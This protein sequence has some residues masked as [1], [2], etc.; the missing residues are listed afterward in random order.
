MPDTARSAVYY[1]FRDHVVAGVNWRRTR[2]VDDIPSTRVCCVCRTIPKRTV[3]L[4]CL[5]ALCVHCHAA[6]RQ[7]GGVLCTLDQEPFEEEECVAVDFPARKAESVKVYCWN[8]DQGCDYVGTMGG[9][10]RHYENECAFHKVECSACN[11]GVLHKDIPAHYAAGC[12]AATA[13]AARGQSSSSSTELTSQILSAAVEDLKAFLRDSQ[14][15]QLLPVVQSQLNEL[16]EH[17][18]NQEVSLARIAREIRAFEKYY[19]A[20][21]VAAAIPSSTSDRR[22]CRQKPWLDFGALYRATTQSGPR[23]PAV[24]A[25]CQLVVSSDD[26][27][28]SLTSVPSTSRRWCKELLRVTYLLTLDNAEEVF[29]CRGEAERKL[30]EVTVSHMS[31]TNLLLAVSKRRNSFEVEIQFD[32]LLPG[33]QCFPPPRRVTALHPD[34]RSKNLNLN[35]RS[36]ENCSCERRRGQLEHLHRTFHTDLDFLQKAGFLR[37]GKMAFKIELVD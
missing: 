29:A 6:N 8:E 19:Q 11:E 5:H 31:D 37:D 30:A 2:L 21:E 16:T 10:L 13:S 15:D 3:L 23:F 34:A 1:R 20:D 17:V 12:S 9:M 28:P 36:G 4:P 33:S 14:Q 32:G 27:F 24:V 18:R 25:R 7:S 26:S 35:R 22:P